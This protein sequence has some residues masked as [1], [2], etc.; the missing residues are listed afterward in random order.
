MN[1][2]DQVA[3]LSRVEEASLPEYALKRLYEAEEMTPDEETQC[4]R[5]CTGVAAELVRQGK[6]TW[7]DLSPGESAGPKPSAGYVPTLQAMLA[8]FRQYPETSLPP[9]A[10]AFLVGEGKPLSP[11]E[12]ADCEAYAIRLASRVPVPS[13]NAPAP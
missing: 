12:M 5:F 11:Q 3:L 6:A 8:L 2:K 1:A 13:Q 4:D 9:Y 7:Q 10:M